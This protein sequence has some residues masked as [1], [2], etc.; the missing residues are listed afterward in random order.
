MSGVFILRISRISQIRRLRSQSADCADYADAFFKAPPLEAA[1]CRS[2][3]SFPDRDAQSATISARRSSKVSSTPCL[4]E[5]A[6]EV[7]RSC[8]PGVA[9]DASRVTGGRANAVRVARGRAA[10]PRA[11]DRSARS[12]RRRSRPNDAT[13]VADRRSCPQPRQSRARSHARSSRAAFDGPGQPAARSPAPPRPADASAPALIGSLG[14]RNG[15]ASVSRP[16][17][18]GQIRSISSCVNGNRVGLPVAVTTAIGFFRKD[19]DMATKR[20]VPQ[21]LEIRKACVDG[22]EGHAQGPDAG[23]WRPERRRGHSVCGTTLQTGGTDTGACAAITP[24]KARI[25]Y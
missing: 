5:I 9:Y 13:H 19:T 16:A 10:G 20:T 3:H 7:S 4:K 15:A 23:C 21:P 1:Q 6:D 22:P 2:S 25:S 14:P 8:H 24:Y 11:P 18:S 12:P 17:I